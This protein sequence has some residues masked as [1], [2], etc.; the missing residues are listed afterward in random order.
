MLIKKVVQHTRWYTAPLDI[1]M[2][3]AAVSKEKERIQ[4]RIK[5]DTT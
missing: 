2:I 5:V 3:H 1:C 4:N